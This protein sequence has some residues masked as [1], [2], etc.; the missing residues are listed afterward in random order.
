MSEERVQYQTN[1]EFDYKADQ[2][3]FLKQQHIDSTLITHIEPY[4][5]ES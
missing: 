3:E 1:E 2:E 5:A 4:K